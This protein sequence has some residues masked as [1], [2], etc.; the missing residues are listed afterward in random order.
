[1]NIKFYI[2]ALIGVFILPTLLS[3]LL[4]LPYISV[5]HSYVYY[6]L[7][8]YGQQIF[9]EKQTLWAFVG[10]MSAALGILLGFLYKDVYEN[11]K[12]RILVKALYEEILRNIDLI[13]TG[14]VERLY[15]FFTFDR[16]NQEFIDKVKNIDRFKFIRLIY[17]EYSYYREIIKIFR[18]NDPNIVTEKQFGVCNKILEYFDGKGIDYQKLKGTPKLNKY[19][20]N[21]D[22]ERL[23]KMAITEKEKNINIWKNKLAEDFQAIFG[24]TI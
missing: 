10:I 21:N 9:N 13:F 20:G 14:E 17:D 11:N 19:S 3:V 23:R 24:V 1:M 18:L 8:P 15:S 5:G 4:L 22:W 12:Y 2:F 7:K 6:L 16:I